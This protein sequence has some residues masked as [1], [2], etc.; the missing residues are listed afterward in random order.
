MTIQEAAKAAG[1]TGKIERAV[2]QSTGYIQLNQISSL[3]LFVP[4][5]GGGFTNW[6]PLYEDMIADDWQIHYD[7]VLYAD[8]KPIMWANMAG[9]KEDD[10]R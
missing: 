4:Y 3:F 10:L 1:K 9:G 8:D 2:W 5:N 7:C 6:C